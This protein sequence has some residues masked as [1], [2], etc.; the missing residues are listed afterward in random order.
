MKKN[1]HIL[2]LLLLS[3]VCL[4][5]KANPVI[6]FFFKPLGDVEKVVK[7][8]KK[9]GNLAKHT[10]KGIIQPVPVAGLLVTYSGYIASSNYNG[11]VILPRKHYKSMMTIVVTPEMVPVALFENTYQHWD[12]IPGIPA[13]MYSCE[14][15][16]DET[17]DQSYWEV[18]DLPFL[19]GNQ[20]PVSAIVIFAKPENIV[21]NEGITPTVRAA[22]LVLPDVYVKKGI[23][24]VKNSSYAL[25]IRHLFKPV[26]VEEKPEP[27]KMITLV[28]D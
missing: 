24:V 8:L 3:L 20:I 13:K 16:Y 7:K 5:V 6:T 22:N 4:M 25:T 19:A 12:L 27:L 1:C 11:E 9:P 2:G 28:I 15:K 10:V 23:N 26:T 21:I 14:Q 17:K 18:K